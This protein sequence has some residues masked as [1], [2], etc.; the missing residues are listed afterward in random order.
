MIKITLFK[1]IVDFRFQEVS[2]YPDENSKPPNGKGLNKPA[3][4][5]LLAVWPGDKKNR[6]PI[7][8]PKRLQVMGYAKRLRRI[9]VR[10]GAVFID[11]RP[12]PNGAWQFRV[13]KITLINKL[14]V[15]L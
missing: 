8:D 1:I 4:V 6:D 9:T 3:V 12:E 15:I 2:I 10:M 7:V 5:T 14:L 11:Y 13:R